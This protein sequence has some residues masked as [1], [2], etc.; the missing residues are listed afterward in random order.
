[1]RAVPR[2]SYGLAPFDEDD[3]ADRSGADA[4]HLLIKAVELR[5]RQTVA[6][7]HERLGP[8]TADAR[9]SFLVEGFWHVGLRRPTVY[10]PRLSN[11]RVAPLEAG[12]RQ[13]A[14]RVVSA[15]TMSR[16]GK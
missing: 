9:F 12:D 4:R 15:S 11:R 13:P 5:L 6:A 3:T 2:R 8:C 1:M 10:M 14:N 7:P 16:P